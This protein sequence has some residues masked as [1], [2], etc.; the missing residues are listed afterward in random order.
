MTNTVF[1]NIFNESRK[2]GA[3]FN[4][5]AFLL[6]RFAGR[7]T[8]VTKASA[9]NKTYPCWVKLFVSWHGGKGTM[10]HPCEMGMQPPSCSVGG[11]AFCR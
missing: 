7:L 1:N 11:L 3:V 10:A 4:S 6:A 2:P 5:P 8:V 9:P